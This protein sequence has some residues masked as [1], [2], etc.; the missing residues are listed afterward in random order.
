MENEIVVKKRDCY[1]I[2][3]IVRAYFYKALIMN[4]LALMIIHVCVLEMFL[5]GIIYWLRSV[6]DLGQVLMG[7]WMSISSTSIRKLLI[8]CSI[9]YHALTAIISRLPGL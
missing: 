8:K 3:N 7:G 9:N 1:K 6:N 5:F 2:G 4:T